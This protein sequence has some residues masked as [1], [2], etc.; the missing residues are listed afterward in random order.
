MD[1]VMEIKNIVS[2]L[3]ASSFALASFTA[4]AVPSF[5][6]ETGKNCSYCHNAWPQLNTKGRSFKELGYRLPDRELMSYKDIAEE[7][8][9]PISAVIVARPYDKKDSQDEANMRALHEVE[10]IV[11]GA[12]GKNWSGFFEFEAEDEAQG[13]YGFEIG[14]PAAVLAYNYNQ[15]IN[16]QMVWGEMFWSD[17]Y[18]LIGDHLRLTRGHV[19]PFDKSFDGDDGN[20]RS[21]RQNLVL[22]GRPIDRLFYSVG[23]SAQADSPKGS[24]S[25]DVSEGKEPSTIHARVAFDVTPDIMVGGFIIDGEVAGFTCTGVGTPGEFDEDCT[26][27]GEV[28][29]GLPNNAASESKLEYQRLGLDAQADFGDSRVQLTF[30]SASSDGSAAETGS[31]NDN[32]AIAVQAYHVFKNASG[33]PSWVPLIRYDTYESSNGTNETDELTLNVTYY[34]EQNV[35]GYVEYWDRSAQDSA[36]DDDRLTVQLALGF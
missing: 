12:A 21:R 24:D 9:I 22:T 30:V 28:I 35:K 1:V 33:A 20:I 25:T 10:V 34:F 7:G 13:E 16:V 6:R 11:A 2:V 8:H 32:D 3:I 26:A 31:E 18:G 36:N 14:V 15:A 23:L 4:E 17:P 29:P 19:A 27:A 5:A